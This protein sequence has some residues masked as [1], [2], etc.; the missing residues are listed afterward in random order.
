MADA[1]LH[2]RPEGMDPNREIDRLAESISED[3]IGIRRTTHA[4]PEMDFEEF[5][6]AAL[7]AETLKR[8]GVACRTGVGGTGVI[9]IIEGGEPIG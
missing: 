8:L 3:L 6:T 1:A 2:E 7:V 4:N 9:G 5:E